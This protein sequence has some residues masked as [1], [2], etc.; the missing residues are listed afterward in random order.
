MVSCFPVYQL[1]MRPIRLPNIIDDKLWEDGAGNSETID[2]NISDVVSGTLVGSRDDFTYNINDNDLVPYY[3]FAQTST[4]TFDEGWNTN[5]DGY[6][7]SFNVIPL[8]NPDD[9]VIYGAGAGTFRINWTI[10][11]GTTTSSDYECCSY[12]DITEQNSGSSDGATSISEPSME[13]ARYCRCND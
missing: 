9:G 8:A 2:L 4:Q 6:A 1:A 5:D 3:G 10:N 7:T 11:D 13:S 12:L